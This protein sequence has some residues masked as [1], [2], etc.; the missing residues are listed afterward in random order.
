LEQ[1]KN[2]SVRQNMQDIARE[3]HQA[4]AIQNIEQRDN[5]MQKFNVLSK[6]IV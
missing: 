2:F 3:I 1:L 4:E 5:L 6:G